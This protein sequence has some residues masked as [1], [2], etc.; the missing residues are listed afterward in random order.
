MCLHYFE[1]WQFS[2]LYMYI[3]EKSILLDANWL[4]PRL[5]PTYVEPYLGSSVFANLQ[6]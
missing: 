4:K 3:F 6:R 2:W 1:K 5:G